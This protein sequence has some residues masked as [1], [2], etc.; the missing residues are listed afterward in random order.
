M[1]LII[2]RFSSN[3]GFTLLETL[4]ALTISTMVLLTL[5]IGMNVVMS[6]WQ[7]SSKRL[8]EDLDQMLALLQ[9]ERALEGAYPHSYL[10]KDENKRTI[11]F[12]GKSDELEWVSVV[13]PGRKPAL[14]AWRLT[15]SQEKEGGLELR[16]IPAYAT[17]PTE[18]L[19]KIEEPLRL[20]EGYKVHFEYYYRNKQ[21]ESD[22][23]WRDEWSGKDRLSLPKAV[24]IYLESSDTKQ[25]SL[26]IVALILANEHEQIS[27]VQLP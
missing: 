20:F 27:P 10:N 8:D 2:A 5:T 6:G 1:S 14:T 4:V 25:Q 16:T 13:S 3:R 9:M 11:F 22:S 19:D 12:E 26:E 21:I 18:N 17:D 7:N 15:P 24:R 23:E